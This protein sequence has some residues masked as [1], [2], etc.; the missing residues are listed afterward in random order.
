MPKARSIKIDTMP[1]LIIAFF[2]TPVSVH[3]VGSS[4]QALP[5]AVVFPRQLL[6]S[7]G[8]L[9]TVELDSSDVR[10]KRLALYASRMRAMLDNKGYSHSGINE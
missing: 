7:E 3:K 2:M 4:L 8:S 5:A 1:P 9:V 10:P 6:L